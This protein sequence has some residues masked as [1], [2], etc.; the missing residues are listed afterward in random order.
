LRIVEE[1]NEKISPVLLPFTIRDCFARP[2]SD[3][4]VRRY[5]NNP[6][7]HTHTDAFTYSDANTFADGFTDALIYPDTNTF[8]DTESNTYVFTDPFTDPFTDAKSNAD[9]RPAGDYRPCK[10][11]YGVR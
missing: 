11:K 9:R 2:D 5:Y 3:I 4:R 10:C 7:S 1:D 8:A 6:D